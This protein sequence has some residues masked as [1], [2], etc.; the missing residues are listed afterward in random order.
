[1]INK[2]VS[3][4][5]NIVIGTM[6]KNVANMAKELDTKI[7]SEHVYLKEVLEIFTNLGMD[8]FQWFYLRTRKF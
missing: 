6:V 3:K 5:V 7:V 4:R 2:D 8:F 1:M